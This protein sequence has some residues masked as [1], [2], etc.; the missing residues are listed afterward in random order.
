MYTV[1]R[2]LGR[3]RLLAVSTSAQSKVKLLSS[4]SIIDNGEMEEKGQGPTAIRHQRRGRADTDTAL[5]REVI[6]KVIS[7]LTRRMPACAW[8]LVAW[9]W[10]EELR[11]GR[12]TA[13]RFVV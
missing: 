13:Q 3:L 11:E 6:L 2:D 9:S 10:E 8:G 12:Q 7:A 5:W 1:Q 4:P